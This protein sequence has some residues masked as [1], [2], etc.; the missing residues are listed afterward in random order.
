MT[1]NRLLRCVWNCRIVR[2]GPRA[3][4]Q[5]ERVLRRGEGM[6]ITFCAGVP[7]APHQSNSDAPSALVRCVWPMS[8]RTR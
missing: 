7:P 8:T 2:I 1:K 6:P 5:V 3:T 4:V